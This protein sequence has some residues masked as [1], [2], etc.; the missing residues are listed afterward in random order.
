[1]DYNLFYY[2]SILDA[3]VMKDKDDNELVIECSMANAQVTFDEPEDEGYLVRLA[4][5]EEPA[6]YMSYALKPDGLQGVWMQ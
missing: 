6:N 1:M 5:R 2:D 3:V 4:K